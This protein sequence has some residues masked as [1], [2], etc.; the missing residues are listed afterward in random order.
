MHAVL[1][2]Y[3]LQ[4]TWSAT[5]LWTVHLPRSD[6]PCQGSLHAAVLQRTLWS[7]SVPRDAYRDRH[8]LL[9]ERHQPSEKHTRVCLGSA[10]CLYNIFWGKWML[11]TST[12]KGAGACTVW[13]LEPWCTGL[14][15]LWRTTVKALPSLD[16][17]E[18]G[19]L[20]VSETPH[21]LLIRGNMS[22][23]DP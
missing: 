14:K 6:G 9:L 4:T 8:Q 7:M 12:F 11:P 5:L 19:P 2:I 21:G 1:E 3:V 20:Q 18:L 16:T 13:H 10:S 17:E 23:I 22:V 15:A